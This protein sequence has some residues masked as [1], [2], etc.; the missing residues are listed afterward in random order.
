MNDFIAGLQRY[1]HPRQ[2]REI[3]RVKIGVAGAGG[4][5]SNCAQLLVRSGFVNF[6]ILDFDVIEASNLNRQFFFYNQIGRKKVEA[7]ADNLRQINAAVAVNMQHERA[8]PENAGAL[9]ADCD[10]VVEAFDDPACKKMLVEA[11]RSS[12]KLLVAASGI[13]G[14]GDSDRIRIHKISNN[15]YVVG[16]LVSGIGPETPPMGPCVNIAAAKQA[17]IVLSHVLNS[18]KD[19]EI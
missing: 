11:Y 6:R 14:W 19:D 3:Q 12:G 1:L 15:F 13:A 5:G 7:L 8:T 17:D 16:D 18:I 2:I 4:L 9:F 10:I